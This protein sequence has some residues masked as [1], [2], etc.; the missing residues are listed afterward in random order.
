MTDKKPRQKTALEALT[1]SRVLLIEEQGFPED[2]PVVQAVTA[3][4]N[5]EIARTMESGSDSTPPPEP[6]KTGDR[7]IDLLQ[8]VLDSLP[9]TTSEENREIIQKA[10]QIRQSLPPAQRDLPPANDGADTPL[11]AARRATIDPHFQEGGILS[12]DLMNMMGHI[13]TLADMDEWEFLKPL[14]YCEEYLKKARTNKGMRRHPDAEIE[15][16]M[17]RGPEFT[18]E[19]TEITARA[20]A[21]LDLV[22]DDYNFDLERIKAEQDLQAIENLLARAEAI[23]MNSRRGADA[24]PVPIGSSGLLSRV[25]S[26]LLR[27]RQ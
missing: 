25:M 8:D 1:L 19:Q 14:L 20:V 7:Q 26:L 3:A 17:R 18:P 27:R 9:P 13:K 12:R 23:I 10:I 4:I 24:R 6:N 22:I 21:E 11:S 15:Y 2:S 16:L 5:A